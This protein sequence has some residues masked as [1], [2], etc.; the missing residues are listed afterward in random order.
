M[1]RH[2]KIEWPP[3][4]N[5]SFIAWTWRNI[6]VKLLENFRKV[7]ENLFEAYFY[8]NQTKNITTIILLLKKK[9]RQKAATIVSNSDIW[10]SAGF[11]L[12]RLHIGGGGRGF[13]PLI[14]GGTSAGGQS[15][16][17]GTHEGGGI[18]LM[19][20]PNFDRLYHKLKVLNIK[21]QLHDAIYRLRFY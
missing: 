15:V 21:L 3:P 1:S 20:G 19:G 6:L 14:W 4:P 7:Y 16:N 11:S 9:T 18:D 13:V 12:G 8:E 17:G 10:Q 5:K 2:P